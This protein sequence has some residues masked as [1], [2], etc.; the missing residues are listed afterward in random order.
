MQSKKDGFLG[1]RMS[2]L[3][4]GSFGNLSGG[5]IAVTETPDRRG[6]RVQAEGFVPFFI[7]DKGLVTNLLGN[8]V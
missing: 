2:Q 1:D 8:Q 3:E 7:V 4:G 6:D 5:A